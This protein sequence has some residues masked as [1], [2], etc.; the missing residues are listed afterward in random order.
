[1]S[2]IPLQMACSGEECKKSFPNTFEGRNQ[3]WRDGWYLTKWGGSAY[4]PDDIPVWI[5]SSFEKRSEK[6]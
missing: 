6:Q 4:C 3:A 5:P 2:D 1:M